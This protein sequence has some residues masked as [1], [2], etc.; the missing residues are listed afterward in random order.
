MQLRATAVRGRDQL[1]VRTPAQASDRRAL[2]GDR[3][4]RFPARGGERPRFVGARPLIRDDRERFA[5]GRGRERGAARET[6][7]GVRDA[8][9][10]LPRMEV[11]KGTLCHDQAMLVRSED[12]LDARAEERGDAKCERE[13][14]IVLLVLERV[15]GLTRYVEPV[16]K[17]ALGPVALR[18]QHTKAILHR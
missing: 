8:R 4:L 9:Q 2:D 5:I 3:A 1:A 13:T 17:L 18:A 16:G 10:A 11:R 7:G 6:T 12:V 14:R 15:H